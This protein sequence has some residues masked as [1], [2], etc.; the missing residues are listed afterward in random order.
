MNIDSLG[1]SELKCTGMG[2]FNSDDHYILL[3]W[4]GIPQKKWSGHHGQQKSPK[5]C[6]W[7]QSQND[8]MISVRFQGKPFNIRVIL[9]YAPNSNAEEAEVE[10]SYKDMQELLEVTSPQKLFFS[11]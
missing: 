7:M 5:C 9:L 2:E 8:R 10:R 11:S 1:I 4:A 3:L 6:T